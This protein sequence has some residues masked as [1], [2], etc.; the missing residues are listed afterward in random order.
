MDNFENLDLV[1]LKVHQFYNLYAL[2]CK[3][4]LVALMLQCVSI[5]YFALFAQ[6]KVFSKNMMHD[7]SLQLLKQKKKLNLPYLA[8]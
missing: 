4:V 3:Q 1:Y 5:C 6:Q 8:H 7:M 2:E